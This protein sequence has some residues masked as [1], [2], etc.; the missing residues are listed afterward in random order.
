MS[1]KTLNFTKKVVLLRANKHL[2]KYLK[3]IK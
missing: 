3:L 2:M 1:E